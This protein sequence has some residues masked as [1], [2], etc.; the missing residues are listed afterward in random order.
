MIS[1]PLFCR[2]LNDQEQL[3][4]FSGHFLTKS[5]SRLFNKIYSKIKI[6]TKNQKFAIKKT[7]KKK[8]TST[9]TPFVK[10]TEK[11]KG[12]HSHFLLTNYSITLSKIYI[13]KKVTEG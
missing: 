9:P 1:G 3:F 7:F 2:Y 11:S 6:F 5:R 12:N 13:Y 8:S 4:V 10:L